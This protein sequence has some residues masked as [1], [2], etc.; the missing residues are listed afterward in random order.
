MYDASL[1]LYQLQQMPQALK[2]KYA[3]M[4]LLPGD[5]NLAQE[6]ELR[7]GFLFRFLVDTS[8]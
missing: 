6:I 7:H 1:P 4:W 2:P 8:D 5:V 3:R